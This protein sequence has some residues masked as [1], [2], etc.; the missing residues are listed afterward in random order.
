MLSELFPL[1]RDNSFNS[2]TDKLEAKA[3]AQ[4]ISPTIKQSTPV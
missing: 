1:I 4:S 3:E 2:L